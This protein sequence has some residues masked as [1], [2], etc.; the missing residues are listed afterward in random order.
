MDYL[1]QVRSTFLVLD[2]AMLPSRW[3]RTISG[4]VCSTEGDRLT[5]VFLQ[6]AATL[7]ARFGLLRIF[8]TG[9]ESRINARLPNAL[10]NF[11][12]GI[13]HYLDVTSFMRRI[14]PLV[15]PWLYKYVQQ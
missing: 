3:I 2:S 11:D 12:G 5:A 4:T 7:R 6:C 1:L 8:H 14:D 15:V 9:E 13:R 10:L